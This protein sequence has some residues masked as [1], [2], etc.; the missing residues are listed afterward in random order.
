MST[1]VSVNPTNLWL[2]CQVSGFSFYDIPFPR[3][4]E[5]NANIAIS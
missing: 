2:N 3:V 5:Y 4:S 1:F